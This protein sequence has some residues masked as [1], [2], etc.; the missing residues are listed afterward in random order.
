MAAGT[1]IPVEQYLR[2]TYRPDCD[3]VDG[4]VVECNVGEYD[5]ARLQTVVAALLHL[6]EAQWNARA[7]VA[8]RVQVEAVESMRAPNPGWPEI[9]LT[10]DEL[11][12]D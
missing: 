2:T 12:A 5:H 11:F 10:F 4:Q 6:R 1:A 9:E 3:Y 7:L 8:Q